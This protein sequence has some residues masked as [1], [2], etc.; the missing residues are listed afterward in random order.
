MNFRHEARTKSV[1]RCVRTHT[2]RARRPEVG[3]LQQQH[4]VALDGEIP[5]IRTVFSH[6]R[7]SSDV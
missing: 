2:H 4:L 3:F 6:I 5:S 7:T 1:H